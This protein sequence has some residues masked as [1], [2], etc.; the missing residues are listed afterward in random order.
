MKIPSTVQIKHQLL[1]LWLKDQ[2]EREAAEAATSA[3]TSAS[4]VDVAA[5]G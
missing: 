2:T 1:M 3:G 5:H 4:H